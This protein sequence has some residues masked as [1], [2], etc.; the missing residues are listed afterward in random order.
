VID[1]RRERRTW[2]S[3]V[4]GARYAAAAGVLLALFLYV[5]FNFRKSPY[6]RGHARAADWQIPIY[7]G[8]FLFCALM[9][10]T[11]S[12]LAIRNYLKE[13]FDR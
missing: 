11:L 8:L 10:G 3:R 6:L 12:I 2:R 9:F 13:H 1:D 5:L 7:E 4:W